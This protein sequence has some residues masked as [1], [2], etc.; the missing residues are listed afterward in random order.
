MSEVVCLFWGN[1][2]IGPIVNIPN[3]MFISNIILSHYGCKL[4]RRVSALV[5]KIK[6][7][8]VVKSN[9]S[10]L[11]TNLTLRSIS[12]CIWSLSWLWCWH[13]LLNI[14]GIWIL[15]V[16]GWMSKMHGRLLFMQGVRFLTGNKY[17][18]HGIGSQVCTLKVNQCFITQELSLKVFN[19]EL[20]VSWGKI[21]RSNKRCELIL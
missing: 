9:M 12:W 19:S 8:I 5:W 6:Y 7:V 10:S 20:F 4:S 18:V 3:L 21:I 15:R 2:G 14:R 13:V 16:W 17:K 11:A 1:M